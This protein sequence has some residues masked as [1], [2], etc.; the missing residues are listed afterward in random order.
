MKPLSKLSKTL[1][2]RFNQKRFIQGSEPLNSM[3]KDKFPHNIVLIKQ[4]FEIFCNELKRISLDSVSGAK[5]K[6]NL[7]TPH[8]SN[9][10][11]SIEK[12]DQRLI[13]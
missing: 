5:V 10:I 1:G 2:G 9:I 13:Q 11:K 6:W 3:Q 8:K 12:K 7:C 4:F